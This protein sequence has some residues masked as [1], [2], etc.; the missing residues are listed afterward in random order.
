MNNPLQLSLVTFKKGAYI[1]VEGKQQ[2]DCFFIIR[3]GKVQISKEVE[4]VEEEG[5]NILRAGDFF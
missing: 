3:E 4:I 5:G 2:A 1:I